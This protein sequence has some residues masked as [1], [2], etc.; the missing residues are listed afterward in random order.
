MVCS[1]LAFNLNAK[2]I[3]LLHLYA[4]LICIFR[5]SPCFLHF[6]G[7]IF[8]FF[9]FPRSELRPRVHPITH[10]RSLITQQ[11]A[12]H[13]S[14][15]FLLPSL[16]PVLSLRAP[17]APLFRRWSR[18]LW[19]QTAQLLYIIPLVQNK[20]REELLKSPL[21]SA[22]TR[23]LFQDSLEVVVYSPLF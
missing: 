18:I 20:T 4:S 9:P 22:K 19:K 12:A 6:S 2:V 3:I 5:L 11:T 10:S 13:S 8:R 15:S 14:P 16:A 7:L 23:E 1:Q 21:V 17:I